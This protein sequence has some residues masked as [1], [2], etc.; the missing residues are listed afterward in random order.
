MN[1]ERNELF[2]VHDQG[3]EEFS[4]IILYYSFVLHKDPSSLVTLK[5]G[6]VWLLIGVGY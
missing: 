6:K 1:S 3:Q 2:I 4:K 5:S